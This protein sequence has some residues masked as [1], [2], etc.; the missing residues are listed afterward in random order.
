MEFDTLKT[1]TELHYQQS[2]SGLQRLIAR[3][4]KLRADID[5]LRA[6]AFEVQS[7]PADQP[8]MQNIGADVIWLRWVAKTT[9]ALNIE[10]AQVLAQKQSLLDAQKRA[11][12]RKTVAIQLAESAALEEKKNR[13]QAQ[14]SASIDEAVRRLT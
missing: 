6:Q 4:S 2:L 3:E 13:A 5:R 8:A 7:L 12:G 11:L 10:L 9:R 14:L 1:L